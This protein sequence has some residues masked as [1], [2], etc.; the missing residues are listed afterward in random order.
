M[1]TDI[2]IP[3]NAEYRTPRGLAGAW[4]LMGGLV[5]IGTGLV[6]TFLLASIL[7]WRTDTRAEFAAA[8]QARLVQ[9]QHSPPHAQEVRVGSLR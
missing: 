2:D 1:A 8:A 5:M 7:Q 3:I 4:G 9:E 6:L